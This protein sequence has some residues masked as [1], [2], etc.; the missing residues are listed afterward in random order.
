MK[1]IWDKIKAF[2]IAV[3]A[4]GAIVA[5]VLWRRIS[6]MKKK[7]SAM[8]DAAAARSE[9]EKRM[10]DISRNTADDLVRITKDI[11]DTPGPDGSYRAV[12]GSVYNKILRGDDDEKETRC[13][14]FNGYVGY[15][16]LRFFSL[17]CRITPAA[18]GIYGGA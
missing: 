16:R 2:V 5:G 1:T 12:S 6:D 17:H 4:G 15:I 3:M 9:S 10:E 13:N 11:E 8:E 14:C 18:A 7:V